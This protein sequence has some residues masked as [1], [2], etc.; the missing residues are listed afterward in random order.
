MEEMDFKVEVKNNLIKGKVFYPAE[1]YKQSPAIILCHG[2]PGG[3]KDP[4][5]PGYQHLANMMKQKGYL[6]ILFNFRGAG[7]STGNFDIQG[8]TEDLK[9]V[10]DCAAEIAGNSAPLILFGFSAGAAVSVHAA[11][12]DESKIAGMILAGCPADF[13]AIFNERGVDQYLN[14][15]R[16][17]GIIK[18]PDFPS[19]LSEW[20]DSFKVVCPEKLINQIKSTP[21]LI[22]HGDQDDVVPVEHAYRLYEKS[23]DPKEL[24]I[25]K[26]GGHRL[27]L[28][29]KA[30]IAAEEWIKNF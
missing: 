19:D 29:A 22:I 3:A 17:I 12:L 4:E 9:G 2:I 10:V 20:A 5:D 25:I 18:S 11:A 30:M 23:F 7:E 8:W 28:D 1:N 26:E 21:K 13:E 27:R 6:T 15:C 14:H 16:E 24:V